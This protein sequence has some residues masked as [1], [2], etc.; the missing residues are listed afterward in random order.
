MKDI[1]SF[2]YQRNITSQNLK[3]HLLTIKAVKISKNSE[4]ITEGVE[5]KDLNNI[6]NHFNCHFVSFI[7]D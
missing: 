4:T 5:G 7:V 2:F 1:T 6:D 3:N